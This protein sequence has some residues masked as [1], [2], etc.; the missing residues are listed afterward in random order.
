MN[1]IIAEKAIAG[2]RIAEILGGGKVKEHREKGAAFFAFEREGEEFVVIPLRGHIM[3][4]D[5]PKHLAP[6][7]GTDLKKLTGAEILYIGKESAIISLLKSKAAGFE[8]AICATDSDREGESI[9][10]EALN[11]LKEGCKGIEAKRANFSAITPEEIEKAFSELGELDYN[12]ADSADARREIDLVWGAVLTRFLSLVSGRLGKE[13]LSAGRVQS[14][15]L[16]LIV[17][18]EK[19]IMAFKARPYW[20]IEATFEKNK[21]KFKASHKKGRFWGKEEAEKAYSKKADYGTVQKVSRIEKKLARPLPFN[22]TS[23]LRAATSIGFSAAG[24]MSIAETLYQRGLI[25][26]PRTDNTVFPVSISLRKILESLLRVSKFY[27]DVESLLARKKLLPSRGKKATK[28]HPPIHPVGV[29]KETLSDQE[30][31][32]YELVCRRF[33]AVLSDDALVEALSVDIDLASEP[34]VA[35]GQRFI[36]WGWKK[37]YPYSKASEVLLPALEKGDRVNLLTLELLSKETKP[38]ARYSQGTLIKVMAENNLGT[39]STRHETI[40]KLYFRHYIEG[41]KAIVPNKIAFAVISALE[42][43]D[44]IIVKPEMTAELEKEMDEIAAGKKGKQE[45]VGDSRK[46]LLQALDGLLK[47]KEEIGKELRS[48]VRSDREKFE[49]TAKGC[50]GTLLTR[51]GRTRKRFLGCSNYPK[52]TET[53]PLPQKGYI[54]ALEKPCPDCS[55]PTIRVKTRRYS[56]SMCIDPACKSKEAWRKKN[57]EKGKKSS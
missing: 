19:E 20:E 41:Q 6:W 32:I 40:Q 56:Y 33:F 45:V 1:L 31:R 8:R 23:F 12:F 46:M 37:V 5:F 44:G 22:T 27:K 25:S 10:L 52:C 7:L 50:D 3:D 28:D 11:A 18:R 47:N 24:A 30:W 14:P 17:G 53:Y 55:K 36:E 4:V 2:R 29:P 34:Y 54:T 38:P 42:K 13:F 26:Y 43:C 16:A 15:T 49:C 57:A 48:A 21:E 39:K 51:T 35:R 9:A